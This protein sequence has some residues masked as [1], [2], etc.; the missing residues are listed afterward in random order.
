MRNQ[1]LMEHHKRLNKSCEICIMYRTWMMIKKNCVM[2]ICNVLLDLQSI[3]RLLESETTSSDGDTCPSC[4]MPFDKGKKRKLI[5]TCGH[6]RCYSCMFKNEQCPTCNSGQKSFQSTNTSG[7]NGKLSA[8]GGCHIQESDLQTSSGSSVAQRSSELIKSRFSSVSQ[9][10]QI[11]RKDSKQENMKHINHAALKKSEDLTARLCATPPQNRRKIFNTKNLRS[12]FG[13]H[14]RT[15]STTGTI[16]NACNRSDDDG[17]ASKEKMYISGKMKDAELHARLGFFLD[18]PCRN[19][20]DSAIKQP[21]QSCTSLVSTNTSPVSTLTGS[22]DADMSRVLQDSGVYIGGSNSIGSLMSM[23]ISEQSNSSLSPVTRRHSVTTSQA[24][25]VED[26]TLF[27]NRRVPIRRSARSGALKGPVDPKIRFAQY[28][29]TQQLT[30][31][32][33]FFE[34]PV[35]EQEPLFIG[36]QWLMRDI[37]NIIN[38]TDSQGILLQGSPGTGKTAVLLQLVDHSCFGRRRSEAM[39]DNEGIYCQVN[40]VNERIKALSS[41][42]VA[43]HFCQ[44]DN[45]LTCLVPDFVHSLAAQLCQAP[46]LCAY[47][48]YLLGESHLQNILSV[49]ECIAD[50]ERAL[51]MGILEP[52]IT[53]RRSGNITAKNCVILIDALCEA[54]YHRPD[55]GDTLATFLAK[56][57]AHFPPWLKVVATVRTQMMEFVKML[58]LTRLSLDISNDTTQKDIYEYCTF[59]LK[60]SSSI[61]NNIHPSGK[62]GNMSNQNKFIQYL[63]SLAKGS[64]LF[65]K[66][67]L[68]LIEC[69]HLV[70]KS[71]SYKVLPVSLAQIFLLRFNLKFPTVTKYERVSNILNVCLATLYPL[72]QVEIFYSINAL[73]AN[74]PLT[75]Q[76]FVESF[77]EL[78]DL[79]VKRLDNTYM[80]FHPALREW[81]IRRDPSESMKF[82]CDFRLGHA[83]IAF[84]LSRLHAPLD[85]ELS[86]ELGHHILK[87]HIYRNSN[88]SLLPRDLQ[89]Y[90]IASVTDNISSSL[91]TLR[92][93]YSP[94]I[95]VS[96]L[97][98]L[99][100][101][102]P[103]FVTDFVGNAPIL[104]IAASEGIV[105]MVNLLLE[106]GADVEKC[107]SQGNTPLILASAKGHCDVVR[108]LVAAGSAL[109]HTDTSGRCALVHAA[110]SGKLNVVKY[111]LASDWIGRDGFNDMSLSQAAQQALVAASS[112][113]STDIVEELLDSADVCIDGEDSITGET[114]LTGAAKCG[115][116]DTVTALLARGASCGARNRKNISALLV[117]AKDNHRAV[118]ERLIQYHVDLEDSDND[119]KTAVIVAAQEANM[120]VIEVLVERGV[121]LEKKDNEGLTALSW[122]CL[123]GHLQTATYLIEKLANIHHTDKTGRTPLDLAAYQGS[124]ALVQMLLDR[125]S[126]IEHVDINGMRPLDRAIACRNV[127]IIQVFLKRGAKLGPT[128]WAMASGKPEI[129]LLLLNKLL[130]D[131]NTLYRKNRLQEASHRYQYALKKFPLDNSEHSSTFNQL[132]VNFLLNHSRCNRKMNNIAEAIDLATQAIEMNPESYEGFHLRAKALLECGQV[133]KAFSDSKSALQRGQTASMDIKNVLIRFHDEVLK[134]KAYLLTHETDSSTDL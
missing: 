19:S 92:N 74:S 96:R 42:I 112:Q 85:G 104:C 132:K 20:V 128:T 67:T 95:K 55:H 134:R 52:L 37:S 1:A 47:R 108:Q 64:F 88:H 109:G 133:E 53:L 60:T 7:N 27:K 25:N 61:V 105:S 81:L 69:G 15:A 44:A 71:S 87:A 31:K 93:V 79:L 33:L 30:L 70:I 18:N 40:V 24:G 59:R 14:R 54:E 63:I 36:R 121:N 99:A 51:K 123:R 102:S 76:E 103:D 66:L 120:D 113:G 125:G 13:S 26:L 43:Y 41:Y 91:C 11:N 90:W 35:Q 72:T 9:L 73:H 117:A 2:N 86:L 131:G 84:R 122:S 126:Q 56:M 80:F 94:N 65:V 119:G 78:S 50:P 57:V 5:D 10:L 45:N 124:G 38:Q 100:G 127:Q 21:L 106:F 82:L 4:Q 48:D 89:A 129:M 29:Q 8:N 111:L 17:E 58:P 83:A 22:S 98:L 62:E 68:D 114:A 116:V 16:E 34:V 49:K 39:R 3:R 23:S 107:N 12:P 101:A 77:N 28:R 6:E 130:E 110:R 118:I 97:L 46:Q 75:W 32:P 115:C